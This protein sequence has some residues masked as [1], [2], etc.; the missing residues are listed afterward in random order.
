MRV[1]V[2]GGTGFSSLNADRSDALALARALAAAAPAVVIDM[3]AYQRLRNGKRN[4]PWAQASCTDT[5]PA[6]RTIA[7]DRL[8]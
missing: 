6:A 8:G 1:T 5:M 3:I 2:L 7:A 4:R